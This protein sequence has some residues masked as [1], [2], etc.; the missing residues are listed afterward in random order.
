MI[1][2]P[3]ESP[4]RKNIDW[5]EVAAMYRSGASPD[6]I[7]LKYGIA[8]TTLYRK[9]REIPD[10]KLRRSPKPPSKFSDEARANL[11]RGWE[12]R[13]AS[14]KAPVQDAVSGKFLK[15]AS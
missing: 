15:P 14:G 5:D 6:E 7:M 12:K 3:E 1:A 8:K 10:I 9:L 4:R 13:R 2:H 11:R